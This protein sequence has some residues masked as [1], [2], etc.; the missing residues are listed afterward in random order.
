MQQNW[1][2]IF[3][4]AALTML[5][6]SFGEVPKVWAQK[7]EFKISVDTTPIHCRNMGLALFIEQLEKKSGGR[8]APKVYHSAQLY[9]DVHVTKALRLGSVEMAVPGTWVLEGFERNTTLTMLPMFTGQPAKVTEDLVDGELGKLVNQSL[10]KKVDAKALGRWHE[11]GYQHV[12]TRERKITKVED[13]KGLKIRHAGGSVQEKRYRALGATAAFIAWPDVPM[14]LVQGVVDGLVTTCKSAEGAKLY[15]AGLKY[16]FFLKNF[17]GY[18]VPMMSLKFWNS[19]SRD[20]QNLIL[21]VWNENV[22][23]Q[24]EI[25]R[26]EQK[27]AE[28]IM[29]SKGIEIY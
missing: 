19:L 27:E 14:A 15:E 8:L 17:Q 25:A 10:E 29:K 28:E 26:K 5:A 11:L 16:G 2:L 9:K 12:W 23:K 24:R 3:A 7:L 1:R 6:L 13:F 4:V 20:L 21:E 22:T 18:Y